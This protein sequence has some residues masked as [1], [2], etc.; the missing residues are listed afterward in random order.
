M[1]LADFR[2]PRLGP[3]IVRRHALEEW[4]LRF[5]GAPVR[6]LI[7]PPGFGK[8][9][10]ILGYLQHLENPGAY[11]ALSP[12]SDPESFWNSMACA[13]GIE[14]GLSSH[15]E[16]SHALAA[17]APLEVAIDC[18]GVPDAEGAAAV[19]RLVR[20]LPDDVSLLI[21]CRSREPF[22]VT[23]LVGEG[24]AVLCGP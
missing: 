20:D 10:A 14:A 5:K 13:L 11:C 17:K 3:S 8:A 15:D 6:F 12:G 1:T 18:E 22:N 4:L 9:M 16:L 23:R 21:A 7:A 2:M 19:L 24:V